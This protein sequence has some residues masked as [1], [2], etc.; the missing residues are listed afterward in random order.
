MQLIKL[1]SDIMFKYI[2]DNLGNTTGL[3]AYLL[4]FPSTQFSAWALVPNETLFNRAL[5]F[6]RGGLFSTRQTQQWLFN[7]LENLCKRHV[8]GTFFV[9][10]VWLKIEDNLHTSSDIP[11]SWFSYGG[12]PYYWLK[13]DA[14][15]RDKVGDTLRSPGGLQI[16]A[17]FSSCLLDKKQIVSDLTIDESTFKTLLKGVQ[18]YYMRAYDGES[19]F[20]L[21]R[22]EQS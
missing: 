1:P 16:L 3:A 11:A 19:F 20:V 2:K 22:L 21:Q 14:F 4:S 10:D 12:S 18:E 13:C 6:E 5:E 15:S 7:R 8:D 17:A 9:Q